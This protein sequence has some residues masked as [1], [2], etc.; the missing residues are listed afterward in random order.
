VFGKELAQQA[1]EVF[2][3]AALPGSVRMRKVVAPFSST[4]TRAIS[5]WRLLCSLMATKML[6]RRAL[7]EQYVAAT[8][9]PAMK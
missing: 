9:R 1:V 6:L 2:V 8:A 7:N 5:A 4:A 3:G